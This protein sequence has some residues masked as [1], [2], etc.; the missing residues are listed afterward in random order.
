MRDG[1]FR[2]DRQLITDR[3]YCLDAVSLPCSAVQL[4]AKTANM[5]IQTPIEGGELSA[6]NNLRQI[7]SRQDSAWRFHQRVEQIK[8]HICQIQF[9]P[10]AGRAAGSGIQFKSVDGEML[11]VGRFRLA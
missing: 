9:N 5:R 8:L 4:A 3:T 2:G 10:V 1:A 11:D 7:L 6:Q